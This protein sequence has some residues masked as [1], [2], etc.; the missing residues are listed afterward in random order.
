[1]LCSY[2]SEGPSSGLTHLLMVWSKI[3]PSVQPSSTGFTP[4][5][6]L[7]YFLNTRGRVMAFFIST[8]CLIM[9]TCM[10]WDGGR[11]GEQV[12]DHWGR[13]FHRQG[14]QSPPRWALPP[15]SHTFL[16][17]KRTAPPL[18]KCPTT[19][20]RGETLR[21]KSVRFAV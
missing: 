17:M 21:P 13:L 1:M 11:M 3:S 12:A 15:T 10:M 14:T 5:W 6:Q 9:F 4:N 8:G 20:R 18:H 2:Q 7:M 16:Q 19:R